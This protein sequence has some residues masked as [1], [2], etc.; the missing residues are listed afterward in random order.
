[1]K[2]GSTLYAEKNLKFKYR[3]NF[4]INEPCLKILLN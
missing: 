1:M 3:E 2:S 4:E